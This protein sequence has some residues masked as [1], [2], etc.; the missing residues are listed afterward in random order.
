[1]H[2]GNIIVAGSINMD[3]VT[4]LECLP[5]PGETVFGNELHYIPGGK[6]SNQAVAASRLGE[7]VYLVGKLGNDVF[8]HSL[9]DFLSKEQLNLDFLF[10]SDTHPTGVALITVDNQSENTVIVVSGSNSQLTKSD[11]VP[12]SISKN[13]VVVS[14]FEIPQTT[15]KY[16]FQRAQQAKAKTILTPAPAAQFIDGLL[17]TVDYLI[18]NETELA[19]FSGQAQVSDDIDNVT[20]SA[21]Q[22]RHHAAQTIIVTLGAK[23]I[24]CISNDE[25][26][27]INEISVE[28]VD[29]TG[30]GDC[31]AGAFAVAIS[32]QMSIED[33]LIF[34]NTAASISVQH[35]GA[36]TSMPMRDTVT[37]ERLA[38]GSHA[39]ESKIYR[40]SLAK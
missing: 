1:M 6:G 30:A 26:F 21:K 11:V 23:G 2:M 22:I 18:V 38:S 28:A 31:F 29:T 4:L 33:A 40:K 16:L 15:I 13:D 9:T 35:L 17:E 34:A 3:I 12:V 36:A 24:V 19:F 10:R 32:E 37:V 20:Q 14:V 25:I 27:R 8:G 5:R 39:V 7:N